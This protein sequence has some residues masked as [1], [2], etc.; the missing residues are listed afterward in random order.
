MCLLGSISD[1]VDFVVESD[2]TYFAL[3]WSIGH[4]V[5][6][7]RDGLLHTLK[8]WDVSDSTFSLQEL[9]RT[10]RELHHLIVQV[11]VFVALDLELALNRFSDAHR[12]WDVDAEDDW[13]IFGLACFVHDLSCCFKNVVYSV[14]LWDLFFVN[15]DFILVVAKLA[16]PGLAH[17]FETCHFAEFV[18]DCFTALAEN[19]ITCCHFWFIFKHSH[20]YLYDIGV[21]FLFILCLLWRQLILTILLRWGCIWIRHPRAKL[22]ASGRCRGLTKHRYLHSSASTCASAS[23]SVSS[24]ITM[25]ILM[26]TKKTLVAYRTPE[27]I[28]LLN[29]E[30]TWC[31]DFRGRSRH[32]ARRMILKFT[33]KVIIVD[34][35]CGIIRILFINLF[36]LGFFFLDWIHETI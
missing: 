21:D 6:L 19:W 14:R 33:K 30:W 5:K 25:K 3:A 4:L 22:I 24:E 12:A 32:W 23:A 2:Q 20:R 13:N 7:F 9:I 35:F 16:S 1:N 15:V 17:V 18:E 28:L 34:L 10:I 31:L 8:S 29:I 26:L 36:H 11:K 27:T